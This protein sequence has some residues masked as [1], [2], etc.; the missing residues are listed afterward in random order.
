[1]TK[2]KKGIKCNLVLDT[3]LGRTTDFGEYPSIAEAIRVARES[4]YFR[5]RIFVGG[6]VFRQGFCN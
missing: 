6:R 5:Y 1:M 3:A 4:G 2:G